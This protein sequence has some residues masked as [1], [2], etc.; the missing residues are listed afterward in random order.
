LLT[1]KIACINQ[2]Y[3]QDFTFAMYP[4]EQLHPPQKKTSPTRFTPQM[5]Q[6]IFNLIDRV[7]GQPLQD[8][9][10]PFSWIDV[11]QFTASE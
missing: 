11:V 8:V 4:F 7:S 6:Q 2:P 10:E 9:G 5:R 1:L 3:L